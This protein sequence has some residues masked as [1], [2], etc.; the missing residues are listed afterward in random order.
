MTCK[1]LRNIIQITRE[2]TWGN[3][4][5]LKYLINDYGPKTIQKI[6]LRRFTLFSSHCSLDDILMTTDVLSTKQIMSLLNIYAPYIQISPYSGS[7]KIINNIMI[8][9]HSTN[10]TIRSFIRWSVK[11]NNY[12]NI[13]FINNSR[14]NGDD[15]F[16]YATKYGRLDYINKKVINPMI[17][18]YYLGKYDY[19][20]IYPF[21]VGFG[22]EEIARGA[23]FYRNIDLIKQLILNVKNP[24]EDYESIVF[25][26]LSLDGNFSE[27]LE[28]IKPY[29]IA[30]EINTYIFARNQKQINILKIMDFPWFDNSFNIMKL[31]NNQHWNMHIPFKISLINFENIYPLHN[32]AFKQLAQSISPSKLNIN[33]ISKLQDDIQLE[34]L[35]ERGCTIDIEDVIIS[36]HNICKSIE[37]KIMEYIETTKYELQSKI[38]L[39]CLEECDYRKL[40]RLLK[41]KH[42][43][44]K[45][46]SSIKRRLLIMFQSHYFLKK[47]LWHRTF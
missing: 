44:L 13:N 6:L 34:I 37:D 4:K 38:L 35:L 5:F 11:R 17:S 31:Y 28:L 20:S 21:I 36:D 22:L 29:C 3:Y 7:S 47:V 8:N 26:I 41:I 14:F 10:Y 9:L 24:F 40:E 16:I 43:K 32:T 23:I 46:I 1:H 12:R 25:A 19:H 30:Y 39:K 45:M 27:Y 42:E 15:I 18:H 33:F 2:D